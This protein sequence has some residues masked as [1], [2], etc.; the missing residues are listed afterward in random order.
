M[1]TGGFFQAS[2]N[3]VRKRI[4]HKIKVVMQN[5]TIKGYHEFH[6]RSHKDLEILI[7]AF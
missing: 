6:A 2:R 4:V 1:F 3:T 7:L 5:S